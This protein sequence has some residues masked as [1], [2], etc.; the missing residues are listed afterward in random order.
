MG[1]SENMFDGRVDQNRNR[2]VWSIYS[3]QKLSVVETG[4]AGEGRKLA[5]ESLRQPF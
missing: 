4:D 3:R 2:D 1:K 5:G